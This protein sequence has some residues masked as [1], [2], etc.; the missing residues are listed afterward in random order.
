MDEVISV[1]VP[2]VLEGEPKKV[3]SEGGVIEHMLTT[4]TVITTPADIPPQITVDVSDL[5]VGDIIR[6]SDLPLPSGVTAG[7][8]ADSPVV[9]AAGAA[10]AEVE[11]VLEGEEAEDGEAESSDDE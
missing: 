4:L 1:D 7:I 11:A 10:P 3:L 6:V 5:S 9:L 2:I 8:D